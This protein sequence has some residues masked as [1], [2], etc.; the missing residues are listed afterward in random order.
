MYD[1]VLVLSLCFSR[2][3]GTSPLPPPACLDLT[4]EEPGSRGN[5]IDLS[6]DNAENQATEANQIFEEQESTHQKMTKMKTKRLEILLEKSR[7]WRMG[8]GG[9][10]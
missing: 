10:R 1:Q 8:R 3:A 6:A 2:H 4:A 9:G 5:P 7:E